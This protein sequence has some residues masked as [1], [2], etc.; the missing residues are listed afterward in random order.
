[1][2][3][4]LETTG[5]DTKTD[6]IEQIGVRFNR[7]VKYKGKYYDFERVFSVEGETEEERNKSELEAIGN[8]L[9]DPLVR[10]GWSS[11]SPL[12]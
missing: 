12:H 7:P 10:P 6:R 5:L 4:D 1:M 3:F 8:F 2:I 11:C 9:T